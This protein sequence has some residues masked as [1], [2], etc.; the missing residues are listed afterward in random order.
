MNLNTFTRAARPAA[1]ALGGLLLAASCFAQTI[2]LLTKSSSD[3]VFEP[4]PTSDDPKQR[5][6]DISKARQ[7]ACASWLMASG[8][9]GPVSMI[10][11]VSPACTR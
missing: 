2:K 5:K 3:I 11:S 9:G 8:G 4:L 6:P 10:S 1:F 7:P